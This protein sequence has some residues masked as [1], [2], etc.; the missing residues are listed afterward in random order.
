MFL[1]VRSDC[2]MTHNL[3]VSGP[4]ILACGIHIILK[5]HFVL[6]WKQ[7]KTKQ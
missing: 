2:F 7:K 3:V 4:V 6:M 1:A 5:K